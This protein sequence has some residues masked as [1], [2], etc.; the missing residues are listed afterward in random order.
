MFIYFNTFT[1]STV[2]ILAQASLQLHQLYLLLLLYKAITS[3]TQAN[4]NTFHD[5]IIAYNPKPNIT[6]ITINSNTNWHDKIM[7]PYNSK[8]HID[9]T[10]TNMTPY[11]PQISTQNYPQLHRP[12]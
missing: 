1:P 8:Y 10:Q 7:A 9:I 11:T 6:P 12:F 4:M 2:A 5:K 3:T